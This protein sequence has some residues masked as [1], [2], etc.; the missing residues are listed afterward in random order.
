[1]VQLPL[2]QIAIL[3]E[4]KAFDS[5]HKQSDFSDNFTLRN[6]ADSFA[7]RIAK[8]L[9]TINQTH[10]KQKD[11]QLP[12]PVIA[13]QITVIHPDDSPWSGAIARIKSQTF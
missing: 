1:M 2:A 9:Q 12:S 8:V 6:D 10:A 13:N 7:T 3:A 5:Y 11:V 4:K